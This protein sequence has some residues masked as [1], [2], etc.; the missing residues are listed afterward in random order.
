L[1]GAALLIE[2][3]QHD[4]DRLDHVVVAPDRETLGIGQSLLQTRG[5]FIHAHLIF[6]RKNGKRRNAA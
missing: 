1:R 3:R 4:V 6:P 5:Q 2:Q